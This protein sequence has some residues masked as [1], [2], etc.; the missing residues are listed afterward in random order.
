[1]DVKELNCSNAFFVADAH[2]LKATIKNDY[3]TVDKWSQKAFSD[4]WTDVR[5][6]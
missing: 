3:H 6:D 5:H 2:F 1:M 4:G